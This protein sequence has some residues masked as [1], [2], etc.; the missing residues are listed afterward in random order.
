[1]SKKT[2]NTIF[3]IGTAKSEITAFE[4]GIGMMGY[5][6]PF[7]IVKDIET[8]LFARALVIKNPKTNQ[9]VCFVN[10]EIAF[11]TIALKNAVV[12]KLQNEYPELGYNE[13]NIIL[14]AQHTHSAAG[15]LSHYLL[16]NFTIVG[17]KPKIFQK[18]L[19]G[20]IE[21][22][23]HATQ[24]TQ[25]ATLDFITG[26]FENEL[27]VA[28][29]R[30]LRAYNAN[31]EVQ[32]KCKPTE[33]HLAIDR[34]MKILRA[35]H[36]NG[37]LLAIWN[38]FGV[39][40]TSISN[41][42]R[43]ICSDNK[44]YAA[45]YTET[46]FSQK[47]NTHTN[48]IAVFAQ[49]AAGDVTPNYIWDKKKK[50]TRGKFENDFESAKY[51]GTLQFEKAKE[52]ISKNNDAVTPVENGIDYMLQYFDFSNTKIDPQFANG[53][54]N[55][56]TVPA[57][58]GFAF[59]EGTKEGPGMPKIISLFGQAMMKAVS[60]YEK[61]ILKYFFDE[62]SNRDIALKY[63]MHG[64][65]NILME[66]TTGRMLGT[67]NIRKLVLPSGLDPAIKQFKSLDTKGI[68]RYTPWVPHILPIQV[69]CIGQLAM[70]GIAA[71]ITTI[72]SKRLADTALAILKHRG[73]ANVIIN[74]YANGY[75]GYITTPEEY[76]C[77]C[78]EGGHTIFGKWTLPAYQT[79]LKNMCIEML[80]PA[81][82]RKILSVLQP[83]VF[84]D[85]EIWYG[86]GQK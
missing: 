78:Y 59:F 85:E 4:Y 18:V 17:F 80:K 64:K 58:Q 14:T 68:T 71:E 86:F 55:L 16:Y 56:R 21:A 48:F 73:I 8:P 19:N 12:Q 49:D 40:T 39:H 51:N 38:W 81:A 74:S 84:K 82:E 20:T 46:F 52:L 41:D 70:V 29:N 62:K 75:S 7:N 77:Q 34:T 28:F 25:P 47:A 45:N 43:R 9:K 5:G 54:H 1:M 83:I 36:T 42:N 66:T 22:I 65:K 44:G 27:P 24:S 50:W 26:A 33:T 76:D 30:S 60:F 11:Y 53:C 69:I 32:P 6:M 37:S 23:L 72:A 57:A 63:K 2:N 3:E 67:F 79:H 35:T 13:Q 61:N 15:G 31:P 10:A